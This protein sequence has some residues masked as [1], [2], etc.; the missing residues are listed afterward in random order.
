[1]ITALLCELVTFS[2]ANLENLYRRFNEIP[3]GLV[4]EWAKE[5]CVAKG[6]V[7]LSV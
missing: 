3:S 1:M 6:V 5:A 4:S 7:S 2:Q